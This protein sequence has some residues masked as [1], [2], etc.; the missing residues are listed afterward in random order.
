[1]TILYIM[2]LD[3]PNKY[4]EVIIKSQKQKILEEKVKLLFGNYRTLP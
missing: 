2:G 1:M 3:L 4:F